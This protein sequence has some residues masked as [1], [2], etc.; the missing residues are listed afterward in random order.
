M[1]KLKKID[2]DFLVEKGEKIYNDVLKKKLESTYK[3]KIV[4]I[5][6]DSGDYFVDNSTVGAIEKAQKKYPDKT[7]YLVR[8]GYPAVHIHR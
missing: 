3:G 7:F 2:T 4:A 5:E 1:P 6:P 8:I